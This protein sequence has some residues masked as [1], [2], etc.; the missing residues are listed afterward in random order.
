MKK[1][2][3]LALTCL[4]WA[5]VIFS[6]DMFIE[7]KTEF[8]GTELKY[9]WDATLENEGSIDKLNYNFSIGKYQV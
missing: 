4:I 7:V 5:N 2:T 6:Q 1:L 9:D 8:A 3:L